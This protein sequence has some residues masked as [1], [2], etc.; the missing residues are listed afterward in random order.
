[1]KRAGQGF[2]GVLEVALVLSLG[3]HAGLLVLLVR[4]EPRHETRQPPVPLRVVERQQPQPEKVPMPSPPK[5]APPADRPAPLLPEPAPKRTRPPREPRPPVARP[6][7]PPAPRAPP[8]PE[9]PSSPRSFG[10]RLENTVQA[11][12]GTGVPVPVG[13]SLAVP[14]T[15]PPKPRLTAPGGSGDGEGTTT[16]VAAVQEMPKVVAD[17]TAE[18]PT[19]ARRLGIQGKVVLELVVNESGRVA[20]ARVLKSLHPLLDEAAL[21]AAKH[22]RFRPG[23]VDGRPVVVKIP[24]TYV[25]VLD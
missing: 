3:L 22:L 10:I 24:Y 6:A 19:E 9:A 4:V 16:P 13:E 2:R 25:F 14:P 7:P 5:P 1:M 21:R 8:T 20:R 18:Y 23:R 11:A 15:A 12:P 17:A